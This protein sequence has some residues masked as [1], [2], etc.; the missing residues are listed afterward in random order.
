MPESF[1]KFI[2]LAGPRKALDA[3]KAAHVVMI[4]GKPWFVFETVIPT[5]KILADAE[6]C[7]SVERGLLI[8]G[9]DDIVNARRSKRSRLSLRKMLRWR[10]IKAAGITDV[11]S[12]K[13][14]LLKRSPECIDRAR[15]A[16]T[17]YEATGYV[18]ADEWRHDNWGTHRC[19]SDLQLKEGPDSMR[20]S[21][22][23]PWGPSV[24]VL[25]KVAKMTVRFE[26]PWGPQE[27]LL[28]RLREM[29]P[30]IEFNRD[31]VHR[32]KRWGAA[33]QHREGHP[34]D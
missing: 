26:T 7:F 23:G 13:R 27:P 17:R 22:E 15:D 10:H 4:E 5:P 32:N 2:H 12:L 31:A 3:F 18:N 16:I 33:G 20:V 21:F 24:P 8:L 29:H 11:E 19:S 9:R 28:E 6:V 34:R 1:P 25:E 14:R 30:D